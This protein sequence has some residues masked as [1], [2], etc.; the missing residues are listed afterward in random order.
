MRS[1][2]GNSAFISCA[3]SK[4]CD[5]VIARHAVQQ[6]DDLLHA[7]RV[8][9]RERLVE[10][11]QRGLAGEGV[12]DEDALLLAARKASHATASEALRVHVDEQRLDTIALFFGPAR[13]S[14]ALGVEAERDEIASANGDVRVEQHLL[15][16]VPERTA[17]TRQRRPAHS[18]L[19]RVGALES[20][21]GSKQRR[22]A[23][24]VRAD[25]PRELALVD[26]EA[27][28]VKDRSTGERDADAVDFEDRRGAH[29]FC[30]DLDDVTAAWM[31]ATSASIH[32]W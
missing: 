8:E 30:V 6:G 26:L 24:A 5:L 29:S 13:E 32:V 12:R 21:N 11:E 14:V 22:L 1:I 2:T 17:V 20:E 15:R 19:A 7:S 3:E 4:H 16:H 9:V 31:D 18:N 25:Q 10:Q 28:V 27:D 23:H